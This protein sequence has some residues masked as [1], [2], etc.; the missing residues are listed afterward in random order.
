MAEIQPI[1]EIRPEPRT[2]QIGSRR[3]AVPP[4]Q[5][6]F[7]EILTERTQARHGLRFSAHALERI[8][9]RKIELSPQDIGRIG[10]AVTLADRKGARE[11]LILLDH[12]AFVVSVNNRTIIT[13][14]SGDDLRDN[15]FTN[16]DSAVVV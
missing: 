14:M 10:D 7:R 4:F 2:P 9:T 8:E 15:V 1:G 6:P 5:Q 16:I 3:E 12:R 11:S 13:A